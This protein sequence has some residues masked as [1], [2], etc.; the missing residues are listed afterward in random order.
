LEKQK[1]LLFFDGT[2]YLLECSSLWHFYCIWIL[3]W[4]AWILGGTYLFVV[5]ECIIPGDAF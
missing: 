3:K 4:D 1:V 2:T 5:A